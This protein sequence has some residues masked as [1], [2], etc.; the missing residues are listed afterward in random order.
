[1]KCTNYDKCKN[2]ISRGKWCSDKCRKDYTRANTDKAN[3][4]VGQIEP[5]QAKSDNDWTNSAQTRTQEEIE[6]HYT[7]AN[8]PPVKYYSQNGGGSGAY[9]PYPQKDPRAAAY[10]IR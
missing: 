4:K 8:F 1:M 5:G 10:A 3:E 2:D 6:A 7:L 9:S